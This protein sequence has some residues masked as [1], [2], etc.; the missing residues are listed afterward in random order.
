VC[1]Q[2]R[3]ALISAGCSSSSCS[4]TASTST[5]ASFFLSCTIPPTE[6]CT[7]PTAT[8]VCSFTKN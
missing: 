8:E 3:P 4:V 2:V 5:Y 1:D 6:G 7:T